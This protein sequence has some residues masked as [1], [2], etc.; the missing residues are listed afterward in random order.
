MFNKSQRRPTNGDPT[1]YDSSI[2]LRGP[3]L[4]IKSMEPKLICIVMGLPPHEEK[5]AWRLVWIFAI[6]LHGHVRT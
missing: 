1:S 3:D 6:A 5:Q 2:E 4:S